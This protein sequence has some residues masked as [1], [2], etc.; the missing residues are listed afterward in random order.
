MMQ[1]AITPKLL[2]L[3]TLTSW[4]VNG[5]FLKDAPNANGYGDPV[6]GYFDLTATF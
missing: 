4:L 5:R 6:Y 3:D 1:P 2:R